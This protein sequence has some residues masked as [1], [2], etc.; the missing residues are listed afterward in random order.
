M[1]NGKC[2]NHIKANSAQRTTSK[3]I[4]SLE[5]TKLKHYNNDAYYQSSRH[6]YIFFLFKIFFIFFYFNYFNPTSHY[7][8]AVYLS[9]NM[10]NLLAYNATDAQVHIARACLKLQ[11]WRGGKVLEQWQHIDEGAA[12][13]EP[14]ISKQIII[15]IVECIGQILSLVCTLKPPHILHERGFRFVP[16][17]GAT[18][19]S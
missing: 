15:I 11:N 10:E 18:S 3:K 16:R 14:S 17:G 8:V 7:A 13:Y 1:L 2:H 5:G 12:P 4:N 19:H 6:F 9:S